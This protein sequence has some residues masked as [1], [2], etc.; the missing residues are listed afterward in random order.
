LL[1]TPERVSAKGGRAKHS[2]EGQGSNRSDN[3][4]AKFRRSHI[5]VLCG[6]LQS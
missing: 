4:V 1:A 5:V 6:I 2:A 3:Y